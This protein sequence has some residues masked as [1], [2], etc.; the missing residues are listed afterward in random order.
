MKPT[1]E[2]LKI[3]NELYEEFQ[4]CGVQLCDP[5]VEEEDWDWYFLM[6]H[7]GAPTRLLDWTDGALIALHFALRDKPKGDLDPALVYVL[8]PDRLR[9]QLY[10]LPE[11]A[12][13]IK[14]WR[15]YAKD[16]PYYKGKEGEW[17]DWENAYL[18]GDKESLQKMNIPRCRCSCTFPILRAAL[19][20]SAVDSWC[21]VPASLGSLMNLRSQI[22]P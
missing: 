17:E 4:R 3:E 20:P 5:R 9:D 12:L 11:T 2:L 8:E 22:P 7:H 1:S 15:D 16:D 6:Q 14:D 10:A 19:Q 21:S 18:P 13:T